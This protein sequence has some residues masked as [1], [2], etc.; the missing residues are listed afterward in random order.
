MLFM[1]FSV[2]IITRNGWGG[3]NISTGTKQN[4]SQYLM[5]RDMLA[6]YIIIPHGI[7]RRCAENLSDRFR[8][9]SPMLILQHPLEE[10]Q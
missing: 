1:S 8:P 2:I 7:E 4:G 3:T 10:I 5:Q 9:Y 6:T